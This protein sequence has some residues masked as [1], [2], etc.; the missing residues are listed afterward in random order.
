MSVLRTKTVEQSIADTEEP[1]QGLRRSL[2][3][4]QLTLLGIGVIIGTGIFVLTGEAAGTIAGPAISISF[5]VAAIV[6]LLAGLCYAEFASVVPAAGSAYTFSYASLGE[7]VAWIIGW[8][9]IL[10]LALG[11][12]TV[13]SGWSQYLQVVLTSSPWHAHPPT[14]LFAD[15]HNLMA[16]VI[17]LALTGLLCFGVKTSS[18]FNGVIVVIKLAV[19]LLVIIAGLSY[20][21]SGNYHPFIP[22]SSAKPAP[23][24]SSGSTLLQDLGAAPGAFG[25][26]GIFSGAALVF[27]AFIGFDIVAT[28]A[29]ETRKPQRDVPIGIFA[30][31]AVCTLLYVAVSLVVTGMVKFNH[32]D[33][34]APLATAFQSVGQNTIATI[35]S[36]GALA[37][38]TSVI[39]VLLMGQSRVFFAMSRDRLLPPAFSTVSKRFGTP[40]RTTIVTG[41]R[42]R[43]GHVPVPAQGARRDGQHRDAVCVRARRHRRDRP[44]S[45]APRARPSVPH[46]VRP[47]AADRLRARLAVAD[48]QPPVDDLAALR[49]VARHRARRLLRLLAPPEPAG[50]GGRRGTGRRRR[51][52][53]ADTRRRR[54]GELVHAF[55][56]AALGRR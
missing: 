51:G 44:A 48:A 38:L 18:Q 39:L 4:V 33:V 11:A 13:A 40:Y 35:I 34:K 10:E 49:R 36:Y 3:P 19:I 1:G 54:K 12:A 56:K 53:A 42:R 32:I 16:A 25:V 15:H 41:V 31:L 8:D 27:F 17:V 14:W 7:L 5:V 21:H 43:A 50:G 6:C 30:S 29:E 28:N 26:G 2:G 23:G 47:G 20:I 22:S 46:A 45:H 9:L 24:G 52:G 37:G 55:S